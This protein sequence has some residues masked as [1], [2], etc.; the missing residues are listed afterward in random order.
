MSASG[1]S[2]ITCGSMPRR[3]EISVPAAPLPPACRRGRDSAIG[4]PYIPLRARPRPGPP[5]RSGRAR[6]PA[7]GGMER[8]ANGPFPFCIGASFQAACHSTPDPHPGG[9]DGSNRPPRGAGGV[10]LTE[11]LCK[12]DKIS[13][14]WLTRLHGRL[15]R[16]QRVHGSLGARLAQ[17]KPHGLRLVGLSLSG[18]GRLQPTSS[19]RGILTRGMAGMRSES[20]RTVSGGTAARAA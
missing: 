10:F 3:E 17:K 6:G 20:V 5:T 18:R 4:K 14:P 7:P 12:N 11:E 9:S 1:G 13:F 16:F 8:A 15:S 2:V 19:K